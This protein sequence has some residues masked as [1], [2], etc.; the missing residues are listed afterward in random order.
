MSDTE[1]KNITAGEKRKKE[2]CEEIVTLLQ[3]DPNPI[4]S[5]KEVHNKVNFNISK[6]SLRNYFRYINENY[7]NV[8]ADKPGDVW[9]LYA[10]ETTKPDSPKNR[11]LTTV[12]IMLENKLKELHQ[13]K[14]GRVFVTSISGLFGVFFLSAVFS[15]TYSFQLPIVILNPT[16]ISLSFVLCSLSAIISGILLNK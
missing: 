8:A 14:Y 15:V 3:T 13:E 11:S 12:L 1:R 6:R 16:Y 9:L 7:D 10:N 4:M 2:R 5:I